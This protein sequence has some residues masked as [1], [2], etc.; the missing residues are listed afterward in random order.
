MTG[1]T[2]Q[3]VK[4]GH[5]APGLERPP[6]ADA[7]GREIF[8]NVS[9]QAWNEW[10]QSMMIKIINEYRLNLAEQQDFEMLIK[11]MRLFLN[12]GGGDEQSQG[13]QGVLEVENP[14]RGRG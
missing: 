2:V 4:L 14:E 7:L 10:Q 13:D 1:R 3:C 9:A 11:Q 12:L 6:F 5:E 8:E